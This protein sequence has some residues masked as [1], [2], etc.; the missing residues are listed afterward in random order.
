MLLGELT[1]REPEQEEVKGLPP[2]TR[3]LR[4]RHVPLNWAHRVGWGGDATSPAD[5]ARMTPVTPPSR[6]RTAVRLPR[7]LQP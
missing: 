6:K 5:A 7:Y 3:L 4:A 1:L 2:L